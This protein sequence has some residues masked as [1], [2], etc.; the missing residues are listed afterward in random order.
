VQIGIAIANRLPVFS[1]TA[2]AE[3]MAVKATL[4]TKEAAGV[5]LDLVQLQYRSGYANYL[6]MLNAKQTY[7]KTLISLVQAQANRYADTAALFQSLSGGW[8]TLGIF[9]RAD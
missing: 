1:L 7:Q 3:T 6:S 2:D 8:W 9:R 4:A 5:T